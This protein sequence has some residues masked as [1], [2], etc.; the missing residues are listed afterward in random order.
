MA[1]RKSPPKRGLWESSFLQGII[2]KTHT[3]NLQILREDTLGATGHLL[4]RPL[5]LTSENCNL[6]RERGISLPCLLHRHCSKLPDCR[7]HS[8]SLTPREGNVLRSKPFDHF[9]LEL[10]LLDNSHPSERE[11]SGSLAWHMGSGLSILSEFSMTV[12]FL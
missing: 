10:V 2:G 12:G 5:L 7:S 4:G 9:S 8:A 1:P 6:Q 3:Q 11:S